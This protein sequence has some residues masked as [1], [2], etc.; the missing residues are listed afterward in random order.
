MC[1]SAA[2]A[3]VVVVVVMGVTVGSGGLVSSSS[4]KSSM[5]DSISTTGAAA[6]AAGEPVFDFFSM[7]REARASSCVCFLGVAFRFQPSRHTTLSQSNNAA[8][9]CA[10]A[11]GC[12]L[13]RGGRAGRAMYVLRLALL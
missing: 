2:A 6:S 4:R 7:P 5:S 12:K 9:V 13:A 11:Y 1:A 3:V 8:L 10:Q